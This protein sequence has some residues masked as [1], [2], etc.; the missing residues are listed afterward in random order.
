MRIVLAYSRQRRRDSPEFRA[1][2]A[3]G[4]VARR[5]AAR[6]RRLGHHVD[7]VDVG[8]GAGW[9]GRLV[10]ARPG[11]VFNLAEGRSGNARKSMVPA[12]LDHL[13]IPYVFS[14]PQAMTVAADKMHA[15]RLALAAGVCCPSGR[16]VRAPDRPLEAHP[17]LIKPVSL[18]NSLGVSTGAVVMDPRGN[19]RAYQ[20]VLRRQLR[21]DP[22]GALV[23]E[24]IEGVDATMPWV[25]GLGAMAPIGYALRGRYRN[26]HNLFSEAAKAGPPAAMQWT[27]PA[28]ITP[29]ARRRL[30]S[31]TEAVARAL[32]LRGAARIDFRVR[33]G[34]AYMLDVNVLP[35]LGLDSLFYRSVHFTTGLDADGLLRHLIAVACA[36]PRNA[37]DAPRR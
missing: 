16:L 7:A 34:R 32:D 18:S 19:V 27:I 28:E 8:A 35:Y 10:R 6:I 23:E 21:L 9:V 29:A 30:R 12:L 1:Y 24:L 14:G 20:A 13:G 3:P 11:L 31:A 2:H 37:P 4:G 33:G 15:K 36:A 22:T 17:V 26:A 5:L 25:E